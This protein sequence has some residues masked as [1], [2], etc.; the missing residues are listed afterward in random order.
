MGLFSIIKDNKRKAEA[1]VVLQ[2]LFEFQ[3][4]LEGNEHINPAELANALIETAWNKRPEAFDGSVGGI[5]P[6]KL[7]IALYALANVIVGLP[8]GHSL[9]ESCVAP[10]VRLIAEVQQNGALYPF[11][12]VDNFLLEHC[13]AAYQRLEDEMGDLLGE[14]GRI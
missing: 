14:L 1:A 4:Q 3:A 7:T 8:Q 13:F 6:H 12:S 10:F 9:R 2:K 11:N 5:R